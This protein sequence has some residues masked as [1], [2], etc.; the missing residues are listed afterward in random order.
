MAKTNTPSFFCTA[1]THLLTKRASRLPVQHL[2]HEA[3]GLLGKENIPDAIADWIPGQGPTETPPT[4]EVL[5]TGL[6][7]TPA[8]SVEPP[9]S[10]TDNN[11]PVQ[12]PA[13]DLIVI[14]VEETPPAVGQEPPEVRTER[15]QEILSPTS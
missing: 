5:P 9:P 2:I 10:D 4:E 1:A 7:P 11:E 12:L 13:Q 6:E 15:I 14:P 8:V 3:V